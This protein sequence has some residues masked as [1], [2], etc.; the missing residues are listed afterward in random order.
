M[1][2][3]GHCEIKVGLLSRLSAASLAHAQQTTMLSAH[4]STSNHDRFNDAMKI[5]AETQTTY[6]VAWKALEVHLLKHS[7]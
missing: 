2:I 3:Q 5:C 4:A 6:E 1:A 7:C